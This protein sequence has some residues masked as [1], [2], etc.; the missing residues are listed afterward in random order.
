MKRSF[1]FFLII[2][3]YNCSFSDNSKFWTDD[4]IKKKAYK[5]KLKEISNKSKNIMLLTFNEY[6]IYINE[7]GKNSKYPNINE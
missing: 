4:V 3:L 1:L 2:F 7:Y 6:E 5:K